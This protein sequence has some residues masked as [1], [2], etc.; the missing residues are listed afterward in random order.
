[1][2][3]ADVLPIQD[4]LIEAGRLKEKG[5]IF[6]LY[7]DEVDKAV[8]ELEESNKDDKSNSNNR[9]QQPKIDLMEIIKPRKIIYERALRSKVCPLLVDSRCRILQ[10]DPPTFKDGE[11]PEKGTLIGAA[12]SPG[13]ATGKVRIINNPSENK[14]ENGEVLC[15]VVTGPAWTPMFASASAVVLQ[16]GGVLQHGA[17]CAR[18]YGKPAVSNIDIHALLKDGMMVSVDGNTGIVKILKE[19]DDDDDKKEKKEE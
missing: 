12:V 15:A 1:M 8:L 18:E 2:I 3:R 7:L 11:K 17:L 5:D 9:E 13:I 14:F 6:H 16:I 4:R 10:P 19:N